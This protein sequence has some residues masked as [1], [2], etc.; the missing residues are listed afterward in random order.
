VPELLDV[1]FLS[2][3]REKIGKVILSMALFKRAWLRVPF[4]NPPL[5]P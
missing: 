5:R 3:A 4:F 1:V 2:T